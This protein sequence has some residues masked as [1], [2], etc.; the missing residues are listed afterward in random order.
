ML[1]VVVESLLVRIEPSGVVFGFT[2]HCPIKLPKT[3]P[4]LSP[5]FLYMPSLY[6]M[7]SFNLIFN[8]NTS[9]ILVCRIRMA[10]YGCQ[11]FLNIVSKELFVSHSKV[12][13]CE[14][15]CGQNTRVSPLL[16]QRKKKVLHTEKS[17]SVITV[18]IELRGTASIPM[19][20]AFAYIVHIP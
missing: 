20:S 17:S 15:K 1:Q 14:T 13:L 16:V 7:P 3:F 18:T 12:W 11:L 2:A 4:N 5:A 10:K 9:F 19:C 6:C 8:E